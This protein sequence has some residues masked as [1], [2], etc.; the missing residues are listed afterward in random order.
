MTRK[1][2]QCEMLCQL[3]SHKR[4]F[5]NWILL[6]LVLTSH[7]H[8]VFNKLPNMLLFLC[9]FRSRDFQFDTSFILK[10]VFSTR[11]SSLEILHLMP[12][13][14]TPIFFLHFEFRLH[15][16]PRSFWHWWMTLLFFFCWFILKTNTCRPR[17]GGLC[18]FVVHFVWLQWK[19]LC[20]IASPA[21]CPLQIVT[22]GKST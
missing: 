7:Q 1:W 3:K 15:C 5:T 12:D 2:K 22:G 19:R 17:S 9:G 10:I 6:R 21:I 18:I 11:P 20:E 13:P 16:W 14:N 8:Y 4:E